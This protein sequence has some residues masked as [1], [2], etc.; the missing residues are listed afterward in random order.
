VLLKIR[1]DSEVS[2][3]PGSSKVPFQH[4]HP[5]PDPYETLHLFKLRKLTHVKVLIVWDLQYLVVFFVARFKFFKV[6]CLFCVCLSRNLQKMSGTCLNASGVFFASN[7]HMEMGKT[8]GH[9]IR[10]EHSGILR[11]WEFFCQPFGKNTFSKNGPE[12]NIE[13][14]NTLKFFS[15]QITARNSND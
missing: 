5:P 7:L 3:C 13:K 10:S 1:F 4:F 11:F 9:T 2:W 15:N 14:L 6:L 12:T 8:I